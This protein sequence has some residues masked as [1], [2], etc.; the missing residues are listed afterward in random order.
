MANFDDAFIDDLL[1]RST[2]LGRII[3]IPGFPDF[4]EEQQEAADDLRSALGALTDE[5]LT[6]ATPPPDYEVTP[7]PPDDEEQ[8]RQGLALEQQK[9]ESLEEE[10]CPPCYPPRMEYPLK[11]E[12]GEYEGIIKYWQ[13]F[14][15]FVLGQQMADWEQFRA[16]Q[17]RVR[18]HYV[19]QGTFPTYQD[20][21]R[22]RRQRYQLP[23]GASLLPDE[24]QQNR[25]E[26]WIEFQDYHLGI[27]EGYEKVLK[28]EENELQLAHEKTYPDIAARTEDI[29][30]FQIRIETQVAKIERHD[31][32][33]RW[34]EQQR[35]AMVAEQD[36]TVDAAQMP[37]EEVG[38][39]EESSHEPTPRNS[40]KKPKPANVLGPKP[41]GI[42]K[43]NLRPRRPKNLPNSGNASVG[44]SGAAT[45]PQLLLAVL[46]PTTNSSRGKKATSVRQPR[47]QKA[48]K[49]VKPKGKGKQ[50]SGRN[51]M[52][53]PAKKAQ[54]DTRRNPNQTTQSRNATQTLAPLVHKTRS[55][56]ISK[57]PDR[58]G[59][60]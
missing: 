22:D 19:R 36:S 53:Q 42:S 7:P 30:V 16:W 50:S 54:K 4:T 8:K 32:L 18:R 5:D 23:G 59:F 38:T 46:V 41:A 24:G 10:G 44:T 40:K 29:R 21:V 3:S 17:A 2:A 52:S 9:R 51:T 27:H 49:T 11:G 6:R 35:V 28:K 37:T 47:A 33:L 58:F 39:Q 31:N 14:S 56:R 20:K 60:P 34:I 13:W 45:R 43:M 1:D 57:R 15:S 55:G 25:L 26:N 48:P 12:L